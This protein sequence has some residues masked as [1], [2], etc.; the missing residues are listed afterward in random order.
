MVN[1]VK[2]KRNSQTFSSQEKSKRSRKCGQE[3][4]FQGLVVA[5]MGPQIGK[6]GAIDI[7]RSLVL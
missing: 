5:M 7:H 6:V 2:D 3:I 1:L 4:L